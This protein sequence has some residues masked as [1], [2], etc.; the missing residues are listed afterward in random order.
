MSDDGKKTLEILC[1]ASGWC[2]RSQ[3]DFALLKLEATQ[4]GNDKFYLAFRFDGSGWRDSTLSAAD[5]SFIELSQA[6]KHLNTT[7]VKILYWAKDAYK[8][9]VPP[10]EEY[11]N[12]IQSSSMVP[13]SY[14]VPR[15]FIYSI[16]QPQPIRQ[17]MIS[18]KGP[19]IEGAE[20]I[21]NKLRGVLMATIIDGNMNDLNSLGLEFKCYKVKMYYKTGCH[22]L[23]MYDYKRMFDQTKV[24]FDDFLYGLVEFS[25]V[26]CDSEGEEENAEFTKVKKEYKIKE[27]PWVQIIPTKLYKIKNKFKMERVEGLSEHATE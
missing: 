21:F 12:R 16:P 10:N 15:R 23:K 6:V 17:P 24:L 8:N 9:N 27:L 14:E 13:V 26:L 1:H 4:E 5:E 7:V 11:S 2:S 22:H 18:K 19:T 3:K 20:E 25:V